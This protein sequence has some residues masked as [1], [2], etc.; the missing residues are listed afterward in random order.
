MELEQKRAGQ[1]P[2]PGWSGLRGPPRRTPPRRRP[3]PAAAP[4]PPPPPDPSDP[5][6]PP[7]PPPPLSAEIV[8]CFPAETDPHGGDLIAAGGGRRAD[9]WA[10][11][12]WA[13]PRQV[14][15]GDDGTCGWGPRIGER[16]F[17]GSWS[18]RSFRIGMDFV[19]EENGF[20]WWWRT[21]V[22]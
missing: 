3:R 19:F 7:S 2:V 11:V 5:Q 15:A 18:M 9:S 1:Q 20:G 17:S 14:S 16:R 6:P 13:R 22:L 4:P 12:G 21:G 8:N 10:H